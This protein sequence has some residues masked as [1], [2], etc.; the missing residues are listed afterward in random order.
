MQDALRGEDY[1]GNTWLLHML[2]EWRSQSAARLDRAKHGAALPPPAVDVQY[3][4]ALKAEFPSM[5]QWCSPAPAVVRAGTIVVMHAHMYAWSQR[6][7]G[8][9]VR[10]VNLLG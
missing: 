7:D 5:A 8:R 1:I 6:S 4:A 9:F 10:A 3:E 2:P